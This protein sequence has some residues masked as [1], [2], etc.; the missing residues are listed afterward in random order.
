MNLLL[1]TPSIRIFISNSI[2]ERNYVKVLKCHR[3]HMS[4]LHLLSRCLGACH[5]SHL[6]LRAGEGGSRQVDREWRRAEFH[7][8]I[9]AHAMQTRRLD[10]QMLAEKVAIHLSSLLLIVSSYLASLSLPRSPPW[11]RCCKKP[12]CSSAALPPWNY[13][14]PS[15]RPRRE[16]MRPWCSLVEH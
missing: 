12:R 13:T 16:S 2:G 7:A 1:D 3:A 10:L 6:H 4:S 11:N 14:G 8:W 5:Q 9:C 15:H